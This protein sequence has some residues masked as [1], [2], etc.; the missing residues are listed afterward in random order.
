MSAVRTILVLL[1]VALAYPAGAETYRDPQGQFSFDVPGGWKASS[2]GA[3]GATVSDGN[4]SYLSIFSVPGGGTDS[5]RMQAVINQI[6]SQWQSFKQGE[7]GAATIAGQK[8]FYVY[9]DGVN[10]KGV[11]STM[12]IAGAAFG[13]D[14]YMLIMAA[15][16]ADFDKAGAA[17]KLIEHSFAVS[18]GAAPSRSSDTPGGPLP[19][20]ATPN[21]LQAVDEP[22]GGRILYGTL[23]AASS[24]QA[25]FK[26]GMHLL[27]G[28]FDASPEL[29]SG[30]DSKDGNLSM[31][32]FN[33]T[34]KGARV[35]GL[36][37]ATSDA[38][39]GARIGFLFDVSD[40]LAKTLGPM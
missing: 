12:R 35:M 21:G 23:A 33:A 1:L 25:A 5:N 3:Q 36:A 30:V 15:P 2:L 8:G 19:G 10:P 32:L 24:G 28:Y 17:F 6:G 16:A 29:Q 34:L 4:S 40:R 31:V 13:A 26:S 20:Q 18:S 38:A 14:S 11:A 22:G 9:F 39:G 27:R 37:V 7:N